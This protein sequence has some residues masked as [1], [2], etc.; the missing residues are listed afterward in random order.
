MARERAVV[1]LG[2]DPNDVGGGENVASL[3]GGLG[4]VEGLQQARR[5]RRQSEASRYAGGFS[6]YCGALAADVVH[7]AL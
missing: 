7:V 2:R 5:S 6:A 1:L 3:G 4:W